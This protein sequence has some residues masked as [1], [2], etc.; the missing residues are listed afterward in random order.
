M[1][2]EKRLE[3]A[4]ELIK[5]ENWRLF[6][7]Y[8]SAFF[9]SE[10]PNLR[11]MANP[12]GDDGRDAEIFSPEGRPNIALQ[13]SVTTKWKEKIKKT[14]KRLE[15]TGNKCTVLIYATNQL[16]GASADDIRRDILNDYGMFLDIRDR[17]YFLERF[18][19]DDSR[20][21]I[22][23]ELARQL[24]DPLLE[25]KGII[26][27]KAQALT[28]GESRAAL[29]FLELQWADEVREKGLTKITFEALVRSAL[30]DTSLENPMDLAEIY[31][32]VCEMLPE[33]DKE[34]ALREI[35]K[36]LR[37]LDKTVVRH[38]QKEERY[39]L[40]NEEV[41]RLKKRL[42]ELQVEDEALKGEIVESITALSD[43]SSLLST[44]LEEAQASAR[45][46]IERFFME[47]GE[48][49]VEAIGSGQLQAIGLEDIKT[50]CQKELAKT[51]VMA[52]QK[53]IE[54]DALARSVEKLLVTPTR[55][56]SRYLRSLSD[57]YTLR[58]FLRQTPDVQEAVKKMFS[59]GEI[60]LDTSIVL[61][62]VAESLLPRPDRNFQR[63]I[64]AAA[65][66]G[67][68]LKVTPGVI[69]EVERHMN[70][71][72]VCA[73]TPSQTWQG[74]IP[75]LLSVYVFRG[76][77]TCTFPD[78]LSTLR[79]S[80]RPED[81]IA[82]YVGRMFKVSRQDIAE[83]TARVP[84]E[85]RTE[86][87]AVWQE[88]H[89]ERRQ[90]RSD[91]DELVALRMASHDVE[92]YVGVIARR[93]KEQDSALGY[94]SWWLTLDQQAFEVVKKLSRHVL[95]RFQ[96]PVMSTDFL[97]NYLAVGPLRGRLA[98]TDGPLPVSLDVAVTDG[99]SRELFDLAG[100]IRKR[101][102]GQP[103]S[104]IQRQVR[105]GLDQAKRRTG[106]I[107]ARGL[108]LSEDID[109]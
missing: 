86:V 1:I 72:Q 63:L 18:R 77:D 87:Q 58:A 60:W 92:N 106:E 44:N 62:L 8:A 6:E 99:L 104:F 71:A 53:P 81:D 28:P 79:G 21:R 15:E 23:D 24:V 108:S 5:D 101:N 109:R 11:T 94:T 88:I 103:E 65:A 59:F 70:R 41:E 12:S 10:Y 50:I 45:A 69:E 57:A 34:F 31:Q 40:T 3:L 37:R 93:N 22:S 33:H 47:R 54:V 89:L 16:I 82:E 75:Y 20:Q 55:Q 30:R 105:D 74:P 90:R 107:H 29:V 25:S 2:D 46:A 39:C 95:G 38:Y 26:Q 102:A 36:A 4:F 68:S 64:A 76:Y 78:W 97:A 27:R 48:L 43:S 19:H 14:A 84:Q 9:A 91:W 35:D 49:F 51:L 52:S 85:L 83:D 98:N 80:V 100:E 17:S 42:V 13:Y 66:A 67:L 96:S 32:R 56:I 61:P 73:A 7:R